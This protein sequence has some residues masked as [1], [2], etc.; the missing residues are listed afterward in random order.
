MTEAATRLFAR[1]GF[2]V[3]TVFQPLEIDYLLIYR[4]PGFRGHPGFRHSDGGWR[5]RI[6]G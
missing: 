6:R 5:R 1:P 2:E 3:I 4:R